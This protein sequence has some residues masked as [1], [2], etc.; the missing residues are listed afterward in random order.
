MH[1]RTALIKLLFLPLL[2]ALSL[3]AWGQEELYF[4]RNAR[5]FETVHSSLVMK[6]M[7]HSCLATT[8]IPD[9]IL[10][11]PA[12]VPLLKKPGVGL[13]L[14]MSNGYESLEKVRS[15]LNKEITQEVVDR[16]FTEGSTI[17]IEGNADI[18]LKTKYVNALFSPGTIKAFSVVRNEADPDVEIFAVQEAGTTLQTG[19]E[20]YRNLFLGLQA[21]FVDRKFIRRRFKLTELA[22]PQGKTL[23][24]PLKQ[25]AY[26]FEPSASYVLDHP[27]KPRVSVMIVNLGSVSE[28]YEELLLPIE[29]QGAIG[30]SPPL[31]WGNLDIT[32]D[33]RSLSY[34][35]TVAERFHLGMKYNYGVMHV[36]G[37]FDA[38]GASAGVQYGLE[39]VQAGIMYSTTRFSTMDDEFYT[40]T[41][42]VQI[43]WKI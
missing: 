40:Q 8:D 16:V 25:R 38:H 21:R 24:K 42:Y 14:M 6:G 19:Y 3:S 5:T 20:V 37:G 39:D 28:E 13:E 9:G 43:G 17:Q 18:Y 15:L 27:W 32:V 11:N 30:I 10:C 1:A 2:F 35:E 7:A 33:Y 36:F 31:V 41:V 26:Y 23:L 29:T 34:E 4:S 12:F 22:T